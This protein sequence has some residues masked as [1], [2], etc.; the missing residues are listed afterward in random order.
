METIL[1]GIDNVIYYYDDI[2]V[3]SNNEADHEQHLERV[4]KKLKDAR[5]KLNASKCVLRQKEIEFLGFRIGKEGVRPDPG[6][7]EAIQQMAEPTNVAE[8]RRVL[9]MINFLGRHLQNLSTILQPM[10]E[11]LEK[12]KAW[13]WGPAQKA[14]FENVKELVTT[15]PTLAYYD[16]NKRT[17]V[18]ADASA[19]GIGGVL[20]QESDGQLKPVAYC[21]RTLS[22]TERRY[23]QIEKE[24]LAAV[25]TCERFHRYLAGLDS[26]TL[27]T[28]HKP[29]VPLINSKDISETPLRCQRMLMRLMRFSVR[30]TYTPGK[31][32][33]VADTL[34]RCALEAGGDDNVNEEVTGMSTV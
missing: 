33:H 27:E 16:V 13:F 11:L 9:G 29:L 14:A 7:V 24:T 30:A 25:W 20:L 28:D 15:A 21:S 32:M 3:F 1:E 4:T 34:S 12:D 26:F 18:S 10:T 8:L 19:Y 17:V 22:Q 2:L 23:A 5:L 31:N 6:K